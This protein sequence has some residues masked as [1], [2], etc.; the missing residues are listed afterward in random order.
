MIE[1]LAARYSPEQVESAMR[2]CLDALEGA[3]LPRDPV[4]IAL[5]LSILI[6]VRRALVTSAAVRQRTRD[7]RTRREPR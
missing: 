3:P 5:V 1:S 2:R 7:R 6:D 4:K